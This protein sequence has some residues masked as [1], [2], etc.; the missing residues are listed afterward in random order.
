MLHLDTNIAV[1]H[2]RGDPFVTERLAQ[3]L[4]AVELS[5]L[6]VA[7]LRY[8]VHTSVD[9]LLA[10]SK[11]DEFLTTMSVIPFDATAAETYGRIRFLLRRKGRPIGDVDMLI[12]AAAM[13][14]GATLITRNWRHFSEVD[15]LS[16]DGWLERGG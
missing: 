16:I 7:E 1:A 4:P 15:G 13:S 9:P 5:S 14:R 3:A 2:L 6:V 10:K 8:G 12:A 11:L